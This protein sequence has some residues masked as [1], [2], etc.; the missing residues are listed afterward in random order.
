MGE[1]GDSQV[2]VAETAGIEEVDTPLSGKLHKP[3]K[4]S[5]RVLRHEHTELS[6]ATFF[7]PFYHFITSLHSRKGL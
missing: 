7:F 6:L 3:G 2:S 4:T 1:N 5:T